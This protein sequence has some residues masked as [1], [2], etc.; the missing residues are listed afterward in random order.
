MIDITASPVQLPGE[1]R[2]AL[3]VSTTPEQELGC[4]IA[5]AIVQAGLELHEM[6]RARPTLEDVFLELTT[7][8]SEVEAIEENH[9]EA[10][11]KVEE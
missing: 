6:R 7:Q 2:L 1:E 11:I 8:E 10:A 4:Q 3:Q 9:E 5:T